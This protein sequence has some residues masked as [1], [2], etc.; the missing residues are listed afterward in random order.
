MIQAVLR[1]VTSHLTLYRWKISKPNLHRCLTLISSSNLQ[2]F[3]FRSE[4]KRF[5]IEIVVNT[6]I[7]MRFPLQKNGA[8]NWKVWEETIR[9]SFYLFAQRRLKKQ[10]QQQD[11]N[12]TKTAAATTIY[13]INGPIGLKPETLNLQSKLRRNYVHGVVASTQV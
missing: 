9:I 2:S 7:S 4:M 8:K 5:P 13:K 12:L 10:Q 1:F 11:N 6:T 3:Y